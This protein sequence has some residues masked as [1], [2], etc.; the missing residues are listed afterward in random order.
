MRSRMYETKVSTENSGAG[1][2]KKNRIS[3]VTV[4]LTSQKSV[5]SEPFARI[6][7]EPVLGIQYVCIRRRDQVIVKGVMI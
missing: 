1:V 5:G 7:S 4:G 3:R 2:I 6:S